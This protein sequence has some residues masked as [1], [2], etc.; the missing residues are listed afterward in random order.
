MSASSP[1]AGDERVRPIPALRH[2]VGAIAVVVLVALFA[3][4]LILVAAHKYADDVYGWDLA[5]YNQCISNIAFHGVPISTLYTDATLNHFGI[6]FSPLYYLLAIPYR[7]APSALTLVVL[8]ILAL[9]LGALPLYALVARRIGPWY[10]LVFAIAYLLNPITENIAMYEF[11]EIAFFVPLMLAALWAYDTER[12][13]TFWVFLVLA[14]GVR[15]DTAA[16]LLVFG[17][18]LFW[19]GRRRLGVPVMVLSAVWLLVVYKGVMPW[20]RGGA[21]YF[22]DDRYKDLGHPWLLLSSSARWIFVAQLFVTVAFLPLFSRRH[23]LLLLPGL[24]FSLLSSFFA[25]YSIRFHY[26]APIFPF[27]YYTALVGLEY[28]RPSWRVALGGLMVAG[29][30]FIGIRYGRNTD[31]RHTWNVYKAGPAINAAANAIPREASV[32]AT[33]NLLPRVSG[34]KRVYILPWGSGSDYALV[35]YRLQGLHPPAT[36]E[37]VRT[38]LRELLTSGQYGVVYGDDAVV[39]LGKG[40]STLRNPEYLDRLG[41]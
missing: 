2:E 3:L 10:G 17:F 37:Q 19:T 38:M 32:R 31:E 5:I 8:Q 13:K 35:D 6:H 34:R 16:Y 7:F 24:A 27:L 20:L 15:E 30:L 41:P 33:G 29:S 28:L 23:M 1:L 9:G 11:H 36:W 18:V 22:F 40:H 4:R 39:L 14:L 25:Q 26:T 12:W 21:P